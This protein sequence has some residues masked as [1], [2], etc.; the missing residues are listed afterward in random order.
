MSSG[1]ANVMEQGP[2]TDNTEIYF[3]AVRAY[4]LGEIKSHLFY[5]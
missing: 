3:M 4:P 5:R 2:D 1:T